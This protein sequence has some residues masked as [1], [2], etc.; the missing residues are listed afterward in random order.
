VW[1]TTI[2]NNKGAAIDIEVLD[3][4]PL[5]RRDEIKVELLDYQGAEYTKE[6]GKLFWNYTIKPND[7]KKIRYSYSVEYPKGKTV[8]EQ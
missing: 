6:F 4:I 2:R 8:S 7:S 5:S 1:E 3:Q